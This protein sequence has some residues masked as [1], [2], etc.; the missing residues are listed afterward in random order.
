MRPNQPNTPAAEPQRGGATIRMAD[1]HTQP[2]TRASW[3]DMAIRRDEIRLPV[4]P[5]KLAPR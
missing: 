2:A 4:A 5:A 1:Y 3:N